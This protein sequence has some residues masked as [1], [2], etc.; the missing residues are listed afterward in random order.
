V[1]GRELNFVRI[2][3]GEIGEP[4]SRKFFLCRLKRIKTFGLVVTT[5]ANESVS[6]QLKLNERKIVA[7]CFFS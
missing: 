6:R 1:N 3:A 5:A 2:F 4:F 7:S